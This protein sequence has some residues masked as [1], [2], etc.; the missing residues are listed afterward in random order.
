MSWKSIETAPVGQVVLLG[1]FKDGPQDYSPDDR[2]ADCWVQLGKVLVQPGP[3]LSPV[4]VLLA[5]APNNDIVQIGSR[6]IPT[7]WH[8]LPAEAPERNET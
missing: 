2:D 1:Y 6:R 8:E 7:H 3:Y 4:V 5:G